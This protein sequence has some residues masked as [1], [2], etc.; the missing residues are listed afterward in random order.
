M[1]QTSEV[2]SDPKLETKPKG[3][4]GGKKNKGSNQDN[5]SSTTVEVSESIPEP[6]PVVEQDPIVVESTT[7]VSVSSTDGQFEMASSSTKEQIIENLQS[8]VKSLEFVHSISL[9]DIDLDKDFLKTYIDHLTKIQEK[10]VPKLITNSMTYMLKEN[11]TSLKKSSKKKSKPATASNPEDKAI[12]K[13]VET[14]PEI[15]KFMDLPE[16]DKISKGELLRK[17]TQYVKYER[18]DMKNTDIVVEGNKRLFKLVGKLN[19][20]FKFIRLQMIERN[21]LTE[22]D[23]FPTQLAYTQIMTYLGYAFHPKEKK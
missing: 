7:M 18:D 14:Y 8:T 21:K 22:S 5:E 19:P 2:S 4:K 17:I 15:L 1:Q 23:T 20:L 6:T 10:L 13:K 11:V 3:K 9:K 12:N 16:G